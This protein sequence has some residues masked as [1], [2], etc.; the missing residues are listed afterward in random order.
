MAAM[1]PDI[2]AE[3]MLRAPRPEMVSE[4]TVTGLFDGAT[5]GADWPA[6]VGC[7]VSVVAFAAA[8]SAGTGFPGITNR[9]LGIA[10]FA[11]ILDNVTFERFWLPF[12]PLSSEKGRN[13]P[14]TLL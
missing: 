5:T 10:T 14:F 2:A 8:V 11:S 4:S 3:P 13:Q 9:A 12:R 7:A 6:L 1:R